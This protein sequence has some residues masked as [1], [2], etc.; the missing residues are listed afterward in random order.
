MGQ[1]YT[2]GSNNGS[3]DQVRKT[4][5]GNGYFSP[6]EFEFQEFGRIPEI[7]EIPE[8]PVNLEFPEFPGFLS[9]ADDAMKM[10]ERAMKDTE[11]WFAEMEKN[12]ET[13]EVSPR[14]LNSDIDVK[15]YTDGDGY[16][17]IEG[18]TKDGY[19][20]IQKTKRVG[21]KTITKFEAY[22]EEV[23]IYKSNSDE[24]KVTYRGLDGNLIEVTKATR[25]SRT[26]TPNGREE[27]YWSK[28]Y[29]GT[30]RTSHA[31][32]HKRK[33]KKSTNGKWL[34]IIAIAAAVIYYLFLR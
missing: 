13:F 26:T 27:R 33:K 1:K 14:S 10:M 18:R 21:N 6:F 29:V 8:I 31:T 22:K 28:D 19:A 12:F 2:N 11:R 7:P 17:V 30:I 15:E 23:L 34:L 24:G 9:Y 5:S 3:P 20:Y 32:V 16:R 4:T 25:T